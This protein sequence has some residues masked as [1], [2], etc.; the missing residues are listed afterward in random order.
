MMPKL[1]EQDEPR[2]AREEVIYQS[3]ERILVAALYA[4][5]ANLNTL[6]DQARHR[7]IEVTLDI[8]YPMIIDCHRLHQVMV[9]LKVA[10]L[11][12]DVS[13]R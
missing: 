3:Q 7:D 13:H 12:N 6:M 2:D 9:T 8:E 11:L 1:F 4:T 10:K 5:V